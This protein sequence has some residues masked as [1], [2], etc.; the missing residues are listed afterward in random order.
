[1]PAAFIL[2]SPTFPAREAEAS[3]ERGRSL[4]AHLADAV[5]AWHQQRLEHEVGAF[6]AERGGRL[7]DDIERQISRKFG[8]R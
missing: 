7:T 5:H 3:V 8:G 6:I 1:M 4:L 2:K